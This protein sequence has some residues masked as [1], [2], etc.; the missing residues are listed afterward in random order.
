MIQN[1]FKWGFLS[2]VLAFGTY[3]IQAQ[4]QEQQAFVSELGAEI[5]QSRAAYNDLRVLCK[6]IGHRLSGSEQSLKA[7]QWAQ[8]VLKN[9]GADTVWLQKVIVPVW[10]RGSESLHFV[11]DGK[12]RKVELLSLGNTTGTDGKV[13]KAEIIEFPTLDALQNASAASIKGK[14]V[15]LNMQFPMELT[16]TFEGYSKT[17]KV[18]WAGPGMAEEKGAVGYIM[19]S[20]STTLDD[21]PHT[22]VSH[23]TDGVP[24]IPSMAIGNTTADELAKQLQ[25][26][27]VTAEML[28]NCRMKGTAESFNVIGELKGKVYPN[29]YILV[30]G[31]LDSWD[32]GEGAHDDGVGC[33][34]SVEVMRAFKTLDYQP[35]HTLRVVLFM[36]EENGNMGGK[37][38]AAEA[39]TKGEKHVFAF[40]SDAGG[41]TPR[42]IGLVVPD[43]QREQVK[44]WAPV[45]QPFGLWDFSHV[46]AGV[47][48]GPLKNDGVWV[49][50]LIPDNQKYFDVHHSRHDVFEA[51]NMREMNMGAAGMAS[52]LYLIDQYWR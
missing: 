42:G 18:R 43:A 8:D 4:T 35:N 14:I 22:G 49:G 11:V 46:G 24:T 26:K 50:E 48:I 38:Y 25:T 16:N 36:N 1:I 21:A 44:S 45:L 52:L 12:R 9:A 17:S 10:E 7:I 31:H 3:N 27:K 28:S 23:H 29:A 13:L 41:F 34:Q 19:R 15:F 6:T 33:I 20:I 32:V 37:T 2:A 30:G 39:K 40:E 5:M 51:V 47:D